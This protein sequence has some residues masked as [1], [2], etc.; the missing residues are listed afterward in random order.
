MSTS[1]L[2]IRVILGEGSVIHNQVSAPF[3][4]LAL[5]D[6]AANV[7]SAQPASGNTAAE[8]LHAR[9]GAGE[10]S[11][12]SNSAAIIGSRTIAWPGRARSGDLFGAERRRSLGSY[13]PPVTFN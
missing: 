9:T 8:Q 13:L 6:F 12:S 5:S 10:L 7:T 4:P 2:H 1:L 3:D 11:K